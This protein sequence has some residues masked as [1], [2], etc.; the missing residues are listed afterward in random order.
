MKPRARK[1][2][3]SFQLSN[4]A[5]LPDLIAL[6]AHVE[7][8]TSRDVVAALRALDKLLPH[9]GQPLTSNQTGQA[10]TSLA[11]ARGGMD[12]G[13]GI[14][15][16]SNPAVS[17]LRAL[18]VRGGLHLPPPLGTLHPPVPRQHLDADS[19]TFLLAVLGRATNVVGE[20]GARDVAQIL[21][22][23]VKLGVV[24]GVGV[25][26]VLLG[27]VLKLAGNFTSEEAAGWL[28]DLAGWNVES[29]IKLRKALEGVQLDPAEERE[30]T[31]GV[32]PPP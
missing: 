20:L 11:G 6:G 30:L 22:I 16:P 18:Q 4:R 10:L 27:R 15:P 25:L 5:T 32:C 29:R 17:A 23:C 19:Q 14:L 3:L 24:P 1:Q 7:A 21:T 26:G 9:T 13:G 31:E 8:F 28:R 2:G 12:G